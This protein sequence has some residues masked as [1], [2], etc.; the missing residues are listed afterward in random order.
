MARGVA[1]ELISEP[2]RSA[3]RWRLAVL[4]AALSMVSPFSIDTFFPSFPAI[5]AELGLSVWELQQILTAYLAPYA[6]MTLLHGPLSDAIGR[7]PV[8]LG[9][10]SLYAM[11]SLA[12]AFAP[13]FATLLSFRVVQGMTAGAGLVVARAIVRDLYEGPRAQR[14]LS[15]ITMI[16][17]VAPAIAPVVGGW[18][19]IA[20]G[21]RAVFGF[22]A[23]FGLTLVLSSALSL[24]ETHPRERRVAFDA[25]SLLGVTKRIALHREFLLLALGSAMNSAALM[26][27]I[28]AAPAIVLEHWSL[29]ETQF[30]WLFGPIICG[31][32]A[33]AW[34]SG[35]VSAR[36][37]TTRQVNFGFALTFSAMGMLV[38]A[39]ASLG[40]PPLALQQ[41]M[42]VLLGFGVQLV[43]PVL[44]LR[45]LDLFPETRGTAASLQSF[46]AIGISSLVIALVLPAI[47]HSTLALAINATVSTLLGYLF[48]RAASRRAAHKEQR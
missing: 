15:L 3:R 19:H 45:V 40:S 42:L 47:L 9:G 5:S 36:V 2:K 6:V 24:P 34:L 18:I 48:W 13:G 31:F 10:L 11:A 8:V 43:F 25:R 22:M 29:K 41:A 12:C 35:V 28:G 27:F 30:F 17:A 33:G 4:L 20:F 46:I 44:T 26:T 23:I 16:F 37:S 7:K 1:I 21:W 38:I 32:V 39:Y 14:M